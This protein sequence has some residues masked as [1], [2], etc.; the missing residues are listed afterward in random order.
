MIESKILQDLIPMRSGILRLTPYE[1]SGKLLYANAITT[2][3]N[4]LTSTQVTETRA[5][6]TLANGNGADGDF[7]IDTTYNFA[8][9]TNVYNPEM[10]ATIAGNSRLDTSGEVS[11]VHPFLIDTTIIPVKPA[12]TS[13]SATTAEYTFPTDTKYPVASADGAVYLE[14]RDNF[15]NLFTKVESASTMQDMTY[16]YD[17]DAHKVTVAAKYDSQPLT[18]TYYIDA[19]ADASIYQA[20]M[21]PRTP[22]YQIEVFAEMKS[23]DTGNIVWLYEKVA[24]AATSGDIPNVTT[25]KQITNTITYNFKSQPVP[26]GIVPFEQ[27]FMN[28]PTVA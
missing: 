12:P 4:Y 28:E 6:E 18:C 5:S 11:V 22:R 13:G 26:E 19:G 3:R 8:V 25:Q 23:A 7:S 1:A 9:S 2:K 15:N 16:F 10:H 20:P 17:A 24:K 14:I 27:V 21:A